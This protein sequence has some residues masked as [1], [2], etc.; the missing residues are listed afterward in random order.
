MPAL[1]V[2]QETGKLLRWLKAEGDPV[3]AGEPLMEIE[4]DKVTVEI[5]APADGTMAQVRAA[6]GEEV[7]VGQVV[8]L[9]VGPDEAPAESEHRGKE[10][11]P[12]ARRKPASPLARRKAR[13]AG[14]DVSSLTGSG[15]EG[16]VTQADVEAAVKTRPD[17]EAPPAQDGRAV[18]MGTVWRRMAERTVASWTSAPHF[19]L[20]REAEAG[21]LVGW[22]QAL[23]ERG[24]EVTL[25]DLL[26][27]LVA[28]ALQEHPEIGSTW[29]GDR[30]IR[31][32]GINI[33]LAVATDEGLVVPVI[34]H[35]DE[36]SLEEIAGRRSDLAT[37]AR[38]GTLA[39]ADVQGGTFT[40]S[41]LGMHDV[42]SFTAVINPPQTAILTVG[43]VAPRV[44]AVDGRPEVRPTV[45]LTLGCDHRAT[46][47]ARGVRFLERVVS[48][49]QE[50]LRL[51]Q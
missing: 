21:E 33:G 43:R 11:G 25:T 12:A 23:H 48:L 49:V 14:V 13:E 32:S 39:L 46:D 15:P 35:A 50:P 20:Q 7:P 10:D 22:R 17:E 19:Y 1:G 45:V 42:D 4:T 8:A 6:E 31:R 29:E 41:N 36:L 34:H 37:R 27:K 28:L 9:I 47:G 40:V 2:A 24:I 51:L 3:R 30:L 44:V 18:E 26:V 16:A 38:G 5:E